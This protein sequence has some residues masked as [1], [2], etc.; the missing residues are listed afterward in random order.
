MADFSL[1]D[2]PD[3]LSFMFYPRPDRSPPPPGAEDLLVPV[4]DGVHLHARCYP[5]DAARPTVLFFHGNGEVVADYDNIAPVYHHFG[6]NLLVADYRGYGRS[7]GRPSFTTMLADAHAVKA[8]AFA[9]LD[10]AGFT[11]GR[12][13]MG[14][15]LGALSAVELAATDAAGFRGLILESGA[16]G[17]RGWGRFARAGEDAAAWEDLRAAQRARLASI[18]LPL[19]SIH[20]A[21]D[22]LIPVESAVEVQAA[23]GSTDKELVI[24]PGAG[25]NDLLAAGLPRYFEALAAFVAR[26]EA[27]S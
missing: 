24:I 18:T 1:L 17:I 20:G 16:A 22:E 8:A 13:L 27:R 19:L 10:A 26:C 9:H 21:R 25:H 5:A 6:L 4:A 7:G 12:Y 15:S 14:R 3:I 11:G 2:R 23:V